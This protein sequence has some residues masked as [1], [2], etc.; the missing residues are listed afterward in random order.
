[1]NNVYSTSF[2]IITTII[3][4]IAMI[5]VIDYLGLNFDVN[6]F[7]LFDLEKNSFVQGLIFITLSSIIGLA[8][9]PIGKYLYKTIR[10]SSWYYGGK[11]KI[12]QNQGDL[13]KYS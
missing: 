9:T 2:D 4:G 5:L 1:M 3:P 6:D 11:H 7:S 8:I 12:K 13:N 10:D